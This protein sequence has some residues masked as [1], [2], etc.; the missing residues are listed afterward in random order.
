MCVIMSLLLLAI[1]DEPAALF[2]KLN[3]SMAYYIDL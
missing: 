3:Q 1:I 2:L